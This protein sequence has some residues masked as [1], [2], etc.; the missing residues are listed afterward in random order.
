M[1]PIELKPKHEY[2][3]IRLGQ[4]NDGGYQ[5]GNGQFVNEDM[6]VKVFETIKTKW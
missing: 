2:E 3:L 6:I 5:I 4:D 1:L